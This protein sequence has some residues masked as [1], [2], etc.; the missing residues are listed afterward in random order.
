MNTL[1]KFDEEIRCETDEE[2]VEAEI[3]GANET[4]ERI[5]LAMITF[6]EALEATMATV[7][8][9]DTHDPGTSD[10]PLLHKVQGR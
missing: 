7:L 4:K 10:I 9:Q 5:C 6:D 3:G 8:V 1:A 2:H